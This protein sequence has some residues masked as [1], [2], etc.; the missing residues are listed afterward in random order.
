MS[1]RFCCKAVKRPE[2]G[3]ESDELN[4]FIWVD[5]LLCEN[6]SRED[7]SSVAEAGEADLFTGKFLDGFDFWA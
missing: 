4:V 5:A 6:R 2:S 3:A 7:V 1:A